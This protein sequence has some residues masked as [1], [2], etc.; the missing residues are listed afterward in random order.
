MKKQLLKT[1]ILGPLIG[2][3]IASSIMAQDIDFGRG[4][5]LVRVPSAYSD[6]DSYPLVILLHGYSSSGQRIDNY[7]KVSNLVDD[8]DFLF[9]APDGT[10]EKSGRQNRFWNASDACCNFFESEVDDSG[11]IRSIIDE[12]KER[13]NIDERRVFLIGH[14]NGGFMSFRMSYEHSGTIAAIASLAGANHLEQREPPPNPVHVLQIHGTNDET[15]QFQGGEIRDNRYPSAIR[16][17]RRWADYNDCSNTGTSRELRDLEASLPGHETGVLK[18][19]IG[20]KDGG[21]AELWTIASGVHSP[22]LSDTFAAQVVEWLL[23]HP[24]DN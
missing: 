16:T 23:A 5:V 11:Y 6:S 7:F 22:M 3:G 21:S 24:K 1:I 9:V 19:E 8:Y 12:M 17:V 20:C 10:Q 2:L 14:S 18:F 4:D 15:I 13:F